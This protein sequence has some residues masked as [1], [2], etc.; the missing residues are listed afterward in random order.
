MSLPPQNEF[1][2]RSVGAP[3]QPGAPIGGPA[4]GAP[5]GQY[6]PPAFPGQ[7]PAP[8]QPQ[9]G[10]PI[11]GP[12]PGPPGQQFLISQPP[13]QQRKTQ[14]FVLPLLIV[15]FGAIGT[16]LGMLVVLDRPPVM[17]LLAVGV[18]SV[19]A[20]LGVLFLKSLDKWEP[21]PP[22]FVIGAFLWGAGISAFISG[23]VNTVVLLTTEDWALTASYSAP[24]I[25]ESTKAAFLVVVLLTSKRARAEFNSL[26][27]AIIYGGMVGL[28]FSWIENI[29]Y[30]LQPETVGEGI[31][32]MLVRLIL[33]AFLHP[34]LTIIVSIGIWLGFNARGAMKLLFPFL[35]W[36]AAVLLHFVHNT[37]SAIFGPNGLFITAG[38]EIVVFTLL[39]VLGVMS[40]SREKATVLAQLPVLVHFGWI[41][42]SQAGWLADLGRRKTMIGNAQGQDKALLRDFVQNVTELA[43]LRG[44][45]DRLTTGEPPAGWLGA[46][47]ELVDLL[48]E[49]RP[50]VERALGETTWQPMQSRPGDNWG[51]FAY[52]G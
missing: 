23:I 33:V 31:Q 11:Q 6:P 14:A 29:G 47:R 21:E 37:S 46:H 35:G 17:S 9:P 44:R 3:N 8:G 2:R 42:A 43:L 52:R 36:C 22:L 34:M 20:G 48:L 49:Q 19:V 39:I 28:G 1:P 32:M 26:T 7:F 40:R 51:S 12:F 27:D 24:L 38:I 30:A 45:L 5:V 13:R 41:T 25:E 10:Y 15:I 16:L 50:Q 18:F 4:T